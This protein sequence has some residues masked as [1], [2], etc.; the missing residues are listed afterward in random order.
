MRES[1]SN[2]LVIL[3]LGKLIFFFWP[4]QSPASEMFSVFRVFFLGRYRWVAKTRR[5]D[6]VTN[7]T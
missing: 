1:D 5:G 7:L 2:K 4:C 6:F 3:K